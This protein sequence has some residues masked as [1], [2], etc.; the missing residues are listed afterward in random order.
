MNK[1]TFCALILG[2][3]GSIGSILAGFYW[4]PLYTYYHKPEVIVIQPSCNQESL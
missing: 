3:F 4:W 1:L 2:I